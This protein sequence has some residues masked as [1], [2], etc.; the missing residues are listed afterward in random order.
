MSA[1]T[2]SAEAPCPDTSLLELADTA[3][4][5]SQ[6]ACCK[7]TAEI[8]S[9]ALLVLPELQHQVSSDLKDQPATGLAANFISLDEVG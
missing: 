5:Q 8:L 1:C 3:G 2:A 6:A 9:D 7:L 4:S